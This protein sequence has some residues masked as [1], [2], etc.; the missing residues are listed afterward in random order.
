MF[1]SIHQQKYHDSGYTNHFDHW[2]ERVDAA[3]SIT[4]PCLVVEVALSEIP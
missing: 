4:G 1:I 3:G 2:W